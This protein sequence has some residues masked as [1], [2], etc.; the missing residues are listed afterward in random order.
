MEKPIAHLPH[1]AQQEINTLIELITHE[2]TD[3]QMIIL[4]GNYAKGNYTL[5]EETFVDGSFEFYQSDYD[6]LVVADGEVERVVVDNITEK[7]NAIFL[8]EPHLTPLQLIFENENELNNQLKE[9]QYLYTDIIKEGIV[10]YDT[11][12]IKL[13][14]PCELSFQ[15]IKDETTDYFDAFFASAC[16]LIE[17]GKRGIEQPCYVKHVSILNRACA[18]LYKTISFVFTLYRSKEENFAQLG[19]LVKR[20]SKELSFVFPQRTAFEVRCFDLLKRANEGTD[21]IRFAVTKEEFEYLV[22]RTE[23]LREIT[24]CICKD[25]IASYEALSK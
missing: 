13:A 24:E 25:K 17:S 12:K 3:C 16:Q 10:I 2:V 9:G 6:I 15:A 19:G 14:A 11:Q 18:C 23:V 20:H 7:Y 8:K 5:W 4:F 1:K 21:D 22:E